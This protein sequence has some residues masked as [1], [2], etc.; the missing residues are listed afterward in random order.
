MSRR[1]S[2]GAAGQS[3]DGDHVLDGFDDGLTPDDASATENARR[4]IDS[5][6]M[7]FTSPVAP[8][9]D[10]FRSTTR[11]TIRP[12]IP[13][14]FEAAPAQGLEEHQ[15]V[16]PFEPEKAESVEETK[17]E[18]APDAQEATI[19]MQA[20]VEQVEVLV[21]DASFEPEEQ[22][23]APA[24][25]RLSSADV[26]E[27]IRRSG[28]WDDAGSPIPPAQYDTEAEETGVTDAEDTDA[29]GA[30]AVSDVGAADEAK[31]RKL[32]KRKKKKQKVE[33]KTKK[34]VIDDFEMLRVLG[35]G[36]AGKV[37]L[38]RHKGSDAL[39]A[40]KAITKR[41]VLA[42]QELQHTMTEQAVLK[43]MARSAT[44]PFVIKLYW[45]FHDKEN[46]FLIMVSRTSTTPMKAG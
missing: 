22:E 13:D 9:Y 23:L 10:T 21:E 46:L 36:C 14:T 11:D 19:E 12:S 8:V 38:V 2:T 30:G 28:T 35:K 17:E 37:L 5:G 32:Q 1:E 39:Y 31:P 24:V 15:T 20:P 18:P 40:L 6:L 27:L 29:F 25:P 16:K 7:D 45:S 4:L 44:D 33:R 26:D 43:R 34:V 42:H 41:H 3:K